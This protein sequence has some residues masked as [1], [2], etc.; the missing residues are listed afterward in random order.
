MYAWEQIQKTLDYIDENLGEPLKIK[1]LSEIAALSPF[2]Y[3][4]L[5]GRLVKKPVMEYIRLRRLA[6]ATEVLADNDNR[7]IDIALDLGFQSH[8]HFTRT[9][10]ETFGMTP[11]EY[12]GNPIPLN[13]M[14]KPQLLL[15]YVFLDEGIPLVTDGIVLEISRRTLKTPEY[16]IGMEKKMPVQFLDGLGV[17]SGVDPL[18]TLW[19][20][21]H[22]QK[23]ELD[24]LVNE[25][26]EIG[27]AYPCCEE[28]YFTYFAGGEAKDSEGRDGY[29]SW[30]LSPGE[31]LICSFEAENF[32]TLVMDTLYKVQQYVFGTWLPR[33]QLQTEP[34]CAERYASHSRD[35]KNMEI[36]LKLSARGVGDL[37]Q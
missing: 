23:R 37:P 20:T 25:G 9:F 8:E 15:N 18:D 32:E 27:V 22:D 10:K 17:E 35:T 21:F 3:Q 4:R 31:Y 5:F 36:W 16:F 1:Q 24:I 34:F 11:D 29:K 2:Y 12:R 26:D 13:R 7:I 6:R 19:R 14:T 30:Q 33:R 28:G